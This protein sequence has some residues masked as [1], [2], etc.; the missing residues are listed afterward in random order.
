MNPF[1]GEERAERAE[2]LARLS[3]ACRQI[4][5]MMEAGMDILSIT[6][7]LRLQNTSDENILRLCERI[8]YDL[9]MGRSLPDAFAGEPSLFS[10]FIVTLIRQ[11]EERNTLSQAFARAS[12]ALDIE[13]Q[14]L[15][16]ALPT[17]PSST[18]PKPLEATQAVQARPQ[19]LAGSSSQAN[20][21]ANLGAR[22]WLDV[23]AQIERAEV[24]WLRAVSGIGAGL[25]AAS[26]LS[27][28]LV[29]LG[30]GAR[31]Q[32]PLS[33][34]LS[35]GVLALVAHAARKAA[36][37]QS[38]NREP[39]VL[40][41]APPAPG[42]AED[43]AEGSAE[44]HSREDEEKATPAPRDPEARP[45]RTEAGPEANAVYRGAPRDDEE[46]APRQVRRPH[47]EEEFD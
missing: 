15:L 12:S 30:L 46:E 3:A 42:A 43:R 4:G 44:E 24:R 16:Q 13:R 32:R 39:Q 18:E 21:G 33:R 6:R 1:E 28:A 7:V 10:P 41:S 22:A 36:Q 14:E 34:A 17:R 26:A 8:D 2:L 5:A 47:H 25:L 37:P 35:A 31:W 9:K 11:G 29:A 38:Q 23:E 19:I 45:L 40:E 27:E 20:D